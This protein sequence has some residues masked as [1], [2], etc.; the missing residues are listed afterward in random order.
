MGSS[1]SNRKE[2]LDL[3]GEGES[4]LTC[5]PQNALVPIGLIHDLP[6]SHMYMYS[7]AA[8]SS[9]MLEYPHC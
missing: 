9:Q 2:N 1:Q 6:G 8:R 4:Y 7:R 3:N 5:Y